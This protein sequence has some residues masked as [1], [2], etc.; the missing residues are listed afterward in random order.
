MCNVLPHFPQQAG[1]INANIDACENLWKTCVVPERVQAKL[2]FS[3][4]YRSN[5]FQTVDKSKKIFLLLKQGI[6]NNC[7][8]SIIICEG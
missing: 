8:N 5:I 4:V 1:D 3:A 2:R 6:F 7:Q